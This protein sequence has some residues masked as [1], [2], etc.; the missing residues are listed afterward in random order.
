LPRAHLRGVN[1]RHDNVAFAGYTDVVSGVGDAMAVQD[2]MDAA[3]AANERVGYAGKPGVVGLLSKNFFLT[4]ITIGIYRFWAATRLRR[5]L[6]SNVQ[7]DGDALEYTGT[8][9]ELFLGFLVAM[10]VLAPL[11]IVYVVGYR[12]ALGNPVLAGSLQAGYFLALFVFLQ[13]ALF[14]SRRYRLSRSAW[15]GIYA[16]QTGSTWRYLGL[17]LGYGALTVVT[18]GLAMPWMNVALQRYKL[19]NT[20]FGDRTLAIEAAGGDLLLR[21]LVVMALV[22]V[23][24]ALAVVPNLAALLHPVYAEQAKG[25]PLLQLPHPAAL[26]FLALSALAGGLAFIW[27]RIESF[28]Y[29][30]SRVTLGDMRL[31]SAAKGSSAIGRVLLFGLGMIGLSIGI[32]L[33]FL[34]LGMAAIPIAKTMLVGKSIAP[35]TIA[36]FGVL[37]MVPIYIVI[38]WLMQ[39]TTYCWLWIPIIRHLATTLEI[40]NFAAVQEI[41]QSTQPRQKLGIADSF[42]LGAF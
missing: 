10:A 15:R 36:V 42:E 23:P 4:L 27:Y 40:Q 32:G 26:A 33:V 38:I 17:Y 13:V 22:V 24:I 31:H 11:S 1:S 39:L 5:Y 34:L 6:W 7:V 9:R 8:G 21:W 14:R 2:D 37:V 12:L 41:A 19:N 18:L 30:A 3:K 29:L 20:W 35:Q 16:G 28:R 25:P